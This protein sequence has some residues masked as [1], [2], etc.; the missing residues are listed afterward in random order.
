MSDMSP[1]KTAKTTT[2]TTSINQLP[3]SKFGLG[4]DNSDLIFLML[5]Y[6]RIVA[7]V[8]FVWMIGNL[9]NIFDLYQ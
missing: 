8:F 5:K 7:L 2:T 9:N 6:F 4:S 1:N 3:E